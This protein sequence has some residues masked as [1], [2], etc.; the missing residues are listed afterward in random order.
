ML[1]LAPSFKPPL[2]D[3]TLLSTRPVLTAATM[4]EASSVQDTETKFRPA[5]ISSP[6][7]PAIDRDTCLCDNSSPTHLLVSTHECSYD[8]PAA[9]VMALGALRGRFPIVKTGG[10]NVRD[11]DKQAV[12]NGAFAQTTE[13][14]GSLFAYE[15]PREIVRN[16]ESLRSE[17]LRISDTTVSPKINGGLQSVLRPQSEVLMTAKNAELV[18]P[19]SASPVLSRLRSKTQAALSYS[20]QTV[21][22]DVSSAQS[23]LSE[24][25]LDIV[26]E[27]K[28]KTP[29]IDNELTKEKVDTAGGKSWKRHTLFRGFKVRGW[30]GIFSPG[31]PGFPYVFRLPNKPQ[32]PPLILL[33]GDCTGSAYIFAPAFSKP[34]EQNSE[35]VEDSIVQKNRTFLPSYELAFEVECGGT[36]G[37]AA[38][39]TLEDGSGDVEVF[40]PSY[41]LNKVHAFR[42]REMQPE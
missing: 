11:G 39:A 40:I 38:V 5:R 13:K 3:A 31:A 16:G 29:E 27:L 18:V 34:T 19:L 1:T 36:V 22:G 37:S 10:A 41:E 35:N 12:E 15:I 30:G 26:T 6:S 23:G 28:V 24:L 4:V 7:S 17:K 32:A 14:G 21:L 9:L 25:K 33:A 2:S 20:S 42:L 8:I